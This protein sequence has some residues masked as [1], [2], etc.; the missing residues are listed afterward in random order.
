MILNAAGARF[1]GE[2]RFP[3]WIIVRNAFRQQ[4]V[5]QGEE[6]MR[7]GDDGAFLPALGNQM[8]VAEGQPCALVWAAAKAHWLTVARKVALPRR[9]RSPLWVPALS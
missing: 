7:N 6:L 4:Q 9:I 3:T 5:N 8:L 2:L 1:R